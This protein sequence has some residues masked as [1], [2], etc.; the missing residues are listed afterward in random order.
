[1]VAINSRFQWRYQY[2]SDLFLVYT[3]N[4]SS[5]PFMKNKNRGIVFKLV[6]SLTL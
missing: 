1:M 6:Y 3:D 2:M 4:Y 5:N